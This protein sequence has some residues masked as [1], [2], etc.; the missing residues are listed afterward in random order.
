EQLKC[1]AAQLQQLE[2]EAFAHRLAE[3]RQLW[4]LDRLR[5]EAAKER[6]VAVA[7]SQKAAEL[8]R[9]YRDLQE[10]VAERTKL[11]AQMQHAQKLESLGL[12]AGGIAHDF[13]NLL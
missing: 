7:L 12:L 13:N 4:E 9:L 5:Q 10:Q 6:E 3:E 8:S 2:R 1:Q 11:Q